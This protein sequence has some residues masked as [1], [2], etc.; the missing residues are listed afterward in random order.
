VKRKRGGKEKKGGGQKGGF[1]EKVGREGSLGLSRGDVRSRGRLV[2]FSVI[3]YE[4]QKDGVKSRN[5]VEKNSS[6][7]GGKSG[8]LEGETSEAY[9]GALQLQGKGGTIREYLLGVGIWN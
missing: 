6:P 4:G 1:S 8:I 7:K 5:W 2:R 9:R 3:P